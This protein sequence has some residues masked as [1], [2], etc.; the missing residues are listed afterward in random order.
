MYAHVRDRSH[1]ATD[2]GLCLTLCVPNFGTKTHEVLLNK[3]AIVVYL[4]KELYF[5]RNLLFNL[6]AEKYA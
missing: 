5:R 4:R 1:K 3:F 2:Y 6:Y